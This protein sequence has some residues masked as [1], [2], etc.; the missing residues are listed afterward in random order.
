MRTKQCR[1]WAMSLSAGAALMTSSAADA[2][3]DPAVNS[4][5]RLPPRTYAMPLAD[6]TSALTDALE[7]ETPYRQSL[8][9]TCG[10]RECCHRRGGDGN[11]GEC[12][13]QMGW[14]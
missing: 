7:P 13:R 4:R 9:G 1:V 11:R 10:C 14:T 12:L 3:E 6:E 5:N 2:W 8:N